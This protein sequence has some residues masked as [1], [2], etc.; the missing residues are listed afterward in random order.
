MCTWG[1]HGD[2]LV[3][4]YLLVRSWM[5]ASNKSDSTTGAKLRTRELLASTSTGN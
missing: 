5:R 2:P 3:E 1:D 4:L